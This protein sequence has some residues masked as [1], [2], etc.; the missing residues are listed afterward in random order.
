M[1]AGEYILRFYIQMRFTQFLFFIN[2]ILSLL[3]NI[4]V[5]IW[6]IEEKGQNEGDK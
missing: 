6:K 1:N 2:L 5:K 3:L 4:S